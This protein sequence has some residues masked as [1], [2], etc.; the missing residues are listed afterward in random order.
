MRSEIE[1]RIQRSGFGKW[2][3]LAA[4]SVAALGAAYFW[5]SRP[6]PPPR[7]TGTVQITNDGQGNGAPMLTDGTRLLFNLSYRPSQVSV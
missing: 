7:I 3:A 2:A 1:K 4:A 5:L 6:L